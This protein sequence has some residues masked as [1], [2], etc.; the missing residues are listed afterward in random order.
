VLFERL[1]DSMGSSG[2]GS[3]IEGGEVVQEL[4]G[5]QSAIDGLRL[6]TLIVNSTVVDAE[7]HTDNLTDNATTISG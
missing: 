1:A 5:L 6:L 7:M 4:S 2:D 3:G